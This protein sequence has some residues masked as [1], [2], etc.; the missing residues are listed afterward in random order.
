LADLRV[1]PVDYVL[2]QRLAAERQQRLEHAS[3][4]PGAPAG[5]YHARQ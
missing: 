2:N 3:H 5:E 1:H 4:S